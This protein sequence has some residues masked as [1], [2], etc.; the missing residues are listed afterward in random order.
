MDV[1]LLIVDDEPAQLNL[2]RL[3]V[4]KMKPAYRILSTPDPH[5]A[6]EHLKT[7]RFN[8]LMTDIKMPGMDG[9]KLLA[10]AR[11]CNI[12]PLEVIILSGFEDFAYA[13]EAITHG[14]CEYLLKPVNRKELSLALARLETAIDA[15]YRADTLSA[16]ADQMDR[17]FLQFALQKYI[18]GLALSA[19][20]RDALRARFSSGKGVVLALARSADRAQLEALAGDDAVMIELEADRF[21]LALPGFEKS[22]DLTALIAR[23]GLSLALSPLTHFDALPEVFARLSD[24]FDTADALN[25]RFIRLSG[26]D[27]SLPSALAEALINRDKASVAQYAQPLRN[28]MLNGALTMAQAR[29]TLARAIPSLFSEPEAGDLAKALT[30]RLDRCRAPEDLVCLALAAL[31]ARKAADEAPRSF[32]ESCLAYISN[33]HAQRL[34]LSGIA[35]AFHYTPS[36]FSRLF[37]AHFGVAFSRFLIDY[38][39]ERGA[40]LL[41]HSDSSVREIAGRVGISD[42]GYFNRLF[43]EKYGV[44]P[45]RYRRGGLL[46]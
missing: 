5:Q 45:L 38:R 15:G 3:V 33:H 11:Q 17:Q 14:V 28:A 23:F 40:E 22:D 32:R 30:A 21:L 1:S 12:A 43:R 8:A 27:A 34:T 20:E 36:H 25:V 19:R 6:L 42:A 9:L 7:G 37:T 2:I 46:P 41:L 16:G 44:S 24:L 29:R 18:N 39:I 26:E 35:A 13:R 10:R 4:E 31:E